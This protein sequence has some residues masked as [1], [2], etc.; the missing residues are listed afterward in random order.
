MIPSFDLLLILLFFF[1]KATFSAWY[2]YRINLQVK[3]KLMSDFYL[4]FVCPRCI[5]SVLVRL[6]TSWLPEKSLFFH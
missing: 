3:Q 6:G 1:I 5:L 2:L 4:G